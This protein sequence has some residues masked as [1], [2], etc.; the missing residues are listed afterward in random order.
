MQCPR[1]DKKRW[2]TKAAAQA[3]LRAIQQK[4]LVSNYLHEYGCPKP[5]NP[6]HWHLGND[7]LRMR[8]D[9]KNTLR[10]GTAVSNR[11]KRVRKRR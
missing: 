4:R 9:L 10:V 7:V 2:P 8:R 5:D 6:E 11:Q 3:A 1:P